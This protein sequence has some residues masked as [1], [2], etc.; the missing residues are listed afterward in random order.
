MKPLPSQELNAIILAGSN[1]T[2][3]NSIIT[4]NPI[5]VFVLYKTKSADIKLYQAEANAIL[6]TQ[7]SNTMFLANYLALLQT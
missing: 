4:V 5:H 3:Q 1:K 2:I 7:L 6:I